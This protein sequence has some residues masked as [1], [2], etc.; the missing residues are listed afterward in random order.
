MTDVSRPPAHLSHE[1]GPSTVNSTLRVPHNNVI[2]RFA[3][4]FSSRNDVGSPRTANF[5]SFFQI[6]LRFC[7]LP[8]IL[9]SYPRLPIR[10]NLVLDVR[11]GIPNSELFSIPVPI[12]LFRI[13]F[14]ITIRQ[15]GDH[16]AC[17]QEERLGLPCWTMI[18]AISLLVDE[19]KCLDIQ[20]SE[21]K[22]SGGASSILTRV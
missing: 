10:T 18:L 15:V 12:E 5:I 4:T 2:V 14:L 7:F 21:F 6:G 9:M 22:N 11:I 13:A 8:A 16:T 20:I 17:A 19:S 3:F 1:Y